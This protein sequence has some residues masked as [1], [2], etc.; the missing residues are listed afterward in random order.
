MRQSLT[1]TKTWFKRSMVGTVGTDAAIAIAVPAMTMITVTDMVGIHLPLASRSSP[2]T[3]MM[4]TTTMTTAGED[5]GVIAGDTTTAVI[6]G[7]ITMA[8][9]TSGDATAVI[10]SG[11]GST[12]RVFR[13]AAKYSRPLCIW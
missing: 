9:I 3:F 12:G 2:S 7:D 5:M 11:N 4:M 13:G 8:V 10:T 6:A 1:W